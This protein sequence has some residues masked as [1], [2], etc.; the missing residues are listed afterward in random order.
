M[1]SPHEGRKC[2][3][4]N[5]RPRSI[6]NPWFGISSNMWQVAVDLKNDK[7]CKSSLEFLEILDEFN[8]LG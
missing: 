5:S 1:V 3:E 4:E 2:G 6:H 7:N 8:I